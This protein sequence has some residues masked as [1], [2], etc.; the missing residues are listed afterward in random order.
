M[1]VLVCTRLMYKHPVYMYAVNAFGETDK[2]F[3]TTRSHVR[4][5]PVRLEVQ[6]W[7]WAALRSAV[8]IALK[9]NKDISKGFPT[10]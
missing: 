5:A 10:F 6:R 7:Q 1:R 2:R 3:Y 4:Y 9:H 8:L